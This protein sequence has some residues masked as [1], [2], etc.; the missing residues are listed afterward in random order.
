MKRRILKQ[1]SLS[2][3]NS[4]WFTDRLL[5]LMQS[6]V[7]RALT[8]DTQIPFYTLLHR[9]LPSVVDTDGR[10]LTFGFLP[11]LP[12]TLTGTWAGC[13][14]TVA[15]APLPPGTFF[16]CISFPFLLSWPRDRGS[17]RPL[18]S[19]GS[20]F[21]LNVTTSAFLSSFLFF[22]LLLTLPSLSP[23]SLPHSLL[24]FFFRFFFTLPPLSSSS[25]GCRAPPG[26]LVPWA[27]AIV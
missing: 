21:L 14:A 17:L 11:L 12:G 2:E 16:N 24:S 20:L 6:S 19:W 15:L 9:T 1:T 26:C 18:P 13:G 7:Q 25:F 23:S 27:P 4:D 22:G 5:R 3:R 10:T 8:A